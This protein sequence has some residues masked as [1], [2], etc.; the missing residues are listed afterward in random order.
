MQKKERSEE[1]KEKIKQLEAQIRKE[2]EKLSH[3]SAGM[4][5]L[6]ANS[7]AQ[8]LKINNGYHEEQKEQRMQNNHSLSP[9]DHKNTIEDLKKETINDHQDFDSKES[10]ENDIGFRVTSSTAFR[11]AHANSE[12][13]LSNS[14]PSTPKKSEKNSKIIPIKNIISKHCSEMNV[15]EDV[16]ESREMSQKVFESF[17]NPEQMNKS[18][19]QSMISMPNSIK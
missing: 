17:K 16:S 6:S 12:Y 11:Q 10:L 14:G 5:S 8:H 7:T 4:Q 9:T 1:L 19:S 3:A 2:E 15:I 18:S 13:Q